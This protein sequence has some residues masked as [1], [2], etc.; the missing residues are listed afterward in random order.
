[1]IMKAQH[2]YHLL[3]IN[4]WGRH[5]NH[6]EH[7]CATRH[8]LE[9]VKGEGTISLRV[10]W[11]I[12]IQQME[13]QHSV[14]SFKGYM[15]HQNFYKGSTFKYHYAEVEIRKKFSSASALQWGSRVPGLL[16][17]TLRPSLFQEHSILQPYLP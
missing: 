8:G 10:H 1:M 6:L 7:Y 9:N 5:R 17:P 11:V 15:P 13:L 3:A 12:R 2:S 16:S 4:R 14:A